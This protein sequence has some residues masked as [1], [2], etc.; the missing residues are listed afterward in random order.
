MQKDRYLLFMFLSI[1]FYLLWAVFVMPLIA[2]P[3]VKDGA[4]PAEAAAKNPDAPAASEKQATPPES[5]EENAAKPSN[6][7]QGLK[8]PDYPQKTVVLGDLD[9]NSK[10]FRMRLTL[11]TRGASVSQIEFSDHKYREGQ[12]PYD[13]LKLFVESPLSQRTLETAIP[14]FDT[15]FSK[16]SA[17]SSSRTLNW[18]VVPESQTDS[19]VEFRLRSPDGQQEVVKR[20]EVPTLT[21]T[22]EGEGAA[23]GI[24]FS[25]SIRNLSNNEHKLNYVMSGPTGLVLEN[26]FYTREFQNI[27][28]GFEN[29]KDSITPKTLRVDEVIKLEEDPNGRKERWS[30]SLKYVGVSV[31]YFAALLLPQ[32][33]QID[34]PYLASTIPQ[35]VQ[36]SPRDPN[37]SQISVEMTSKDL[38]LPAANK[39]A[40]SEVTHKYLFY[41]GPK[42]PEYL[43][44]LGAEGVIPYGMS[45]GLGITQFMQ[46]YL[47][48]LHNLFPEWAWPWGWAI[49]LL[50]V[51]VRMCMLPL[52]LKQARSAARMQ[53]LQPELAALKKKYANDKEK[54]AREQWDLFKRNKVNPLGGCLPLL[55]Q[56]PIFIGL[57]QALNISVDLR[58]AEFLWIKNL[59]APD[60]LFQFPFVIQGI[61]FPMFGRIFAL[62]PSFNLLPLLTVGLFLV[63]QK[64]FMP[65]AMD[66]EQRLQQKMMTYMMVLMGLMF[67]GVPA[68]LCV[69][70]ISSSI[71]SIV[72]RKSLPK[73]TKTNTPTIVKTEEV[74]AANGTKQV[75]PGKKSDQAPAKE[76]LATRLLDWA[77]NVSRQSNA[78]G[79]ISKANNKK[80]K[81]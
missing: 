32:E 10:K 4:K 43:R 47:K 29:S 6:V 3:K 75:N 78:P 31:Q 60:A 20:F 64:L 41:A 76:N 56:L 53:E 42:R 15:E 12:P 71:W 59:A 2:P 19:S 1:G 22:P 62:G 68:G 11:D 8:L 18:E 65:P 40:P 39:D 57:Y 17:G 21:E 26:S 61:P 80:K 30:K 35:L 79:T 24:K 9:R 67:Y 69:Y 54:F 16:L 58:M 7:V 63:Q 51:T 77:D 36:K 50:T 55:I 37:H 74:E 33:S 49:I 14:A 34:Q 44:P 66:E 23:Y 5:S 38:E 73:I 52:S 13:P 48:F 28:V 72:E 45:G 25:I 46:A 81:S 70:F 27:N